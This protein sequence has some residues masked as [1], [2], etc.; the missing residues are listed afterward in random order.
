MCFIAKI[1]TNVVVRTNKYIFIGTR[2]RSWTHKSW[3][4][5][6]IGKHL[7]KGETFTTAADYRAKEKHNWEYDLNYTNNHTVGFLRN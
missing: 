3:M 2:A 6:F 4:L 5:T 1:T 7:Q